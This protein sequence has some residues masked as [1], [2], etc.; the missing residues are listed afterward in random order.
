MSNP[1][2]SNPKDKEESD[3]SE[4][5]MLNPPNAI[6]GWKALILRIFSHEVLAPLWAETYSILTESL[7][8]CQRC[9]Q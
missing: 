2:D 4:K 3:L 1:I 8:R 5:N 9:R 7:T 6:F